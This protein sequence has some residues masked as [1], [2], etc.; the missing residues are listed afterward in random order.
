[1]G[2]AT[3]EAIVGAA[4]ARRRTVLGSSHFNIRPGRKLMVQ[5]PLTEAGRSLLRRHR[6]VPARLVVTVEGGATQQRSIKIHPDDYRN[7]D[8]DE[9]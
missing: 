4:A 2:A 3:L 8:F 7:R 6:T 5:I 1:M 9:R